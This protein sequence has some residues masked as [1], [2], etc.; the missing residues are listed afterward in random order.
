MASTVRTNA[1]ILKA[2]LKTD[3]ENKHLEGLARWLVHARTDGHWASTQNNAFAIMALTDYIR[4][5]EEEL[6]DFILL[7]V[8][9]FEPIVETDFRSFDTPPLERKVSLR[10]LPIGRKIPLEL[11]LDG[12]GGAYYNIRLR[13][14]SS[15]LAL[16]PRSAGFDLTRTYSR[17]NAAGEPMPATG[18]FRRGDLVRVD[19]TLLVP[20]QRQWVVLE[21]MLPAG[22]EPINFDLATAPQHLQKLLDEGYRPEEFYRNYWYEHREIRPD[23]VAVFAQSLNEGAY[24]F[25][26]LARAATPGT[27]AA[28][29]PKAEEMYSP[30][31]SGH[32][33]GM[34]LEIEP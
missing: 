5:V 15:E 6:P 16:E 12:S 4:V 19:I 17:I 13:Y 22:L 14:A 2:L 34:I 25:S 8:L 33:Q 28:P 10:D 27:F 1:V 29:G 11:K 32:G 23:R 24:N 18:S 9:N 20:T 7:A 30:E 3:P 31:I 21:D 26:Y